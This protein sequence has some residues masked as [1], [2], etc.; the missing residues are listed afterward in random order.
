MMSGMSPKIVSLILSMFLI[1][2]GCSS[3]D[4]NKPVYATR[5]RVLYNN[6]PLVGAKVTFYPH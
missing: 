4:Q 1:T 5:G 6:Q 3:R 2:L